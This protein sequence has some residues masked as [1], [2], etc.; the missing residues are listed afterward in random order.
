MD[1]RTRSCF[2]KH[3]LFSNYINPTISHGAKTLKRNAYYEIDDPA[4]NYL[5]KPAILLSGNINFVSVIK[6]NATAIYLGESKEPIVIEPAALNFYYEGLL[7]F[8]ADIIDSSMLKKDLQD[9]LKIVSNFVKEVCGKNKKTHEERKSLLKEMAAK[10]D[11]SNTIYIGKKNLPVPVLQLQNIIDENIGVCRHYAL[12]SAYLLGRLIIDGKI[13]GGEI[14]LVRDYVK[15][16]GGHTWLHY[17]QKDDNTRWLIDN[18]WGVIADLNAPTKFTSPLGKN[19]LA[20]YG[21]KAI[22]NMNERYP[23]PARVNPSN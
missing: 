19:P 21:E 18:Y 9:I 2:E 17:H 5:N 4:V 14:Y 7:T 20:S 10:L 16:G 1:T 8:Y 22:Q 15:S 13:P 11:E 23:A 3:T 12:F 6:D